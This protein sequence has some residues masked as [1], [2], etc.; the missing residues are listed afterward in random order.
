MN[1]VCEFSKTDRLNLAKP[2]AYD[3]IDNNSC[4]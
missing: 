4:K 1:I 3:I 2:Q